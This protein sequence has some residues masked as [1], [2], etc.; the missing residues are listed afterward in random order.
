VG[1]PARLPIFLPSK[2]THPTLF[3]R[4]G[5]RKRWGTKHLALAIGVVEYNFDCERSADNPDAVESDSI[6]LPFDLFD[7][8]QRWF[9][10]GMPEVA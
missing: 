1:R 5:D 4:R 10:D 2:A 8:V 9:R 3:G 6:G 7:E